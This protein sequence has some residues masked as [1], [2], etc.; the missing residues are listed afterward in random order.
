[1]VFENEFDKNLAAGRDS[2]E[3]I[4]E[5]RLPIHHS[6]ISKEETTNIEDIDLVLSHPQAILQCLDIIDKYKWE[7]RDVSSTSAAVTDILDNRFNMAAIAHKDAIIPGTHVLR[8][9]VQT[10]SNNLTRFLLLKRITHAS[11]PSNWDRAYF[12]LGTIEGSNHRRQAIPIALTLFIEYGVKMR[13]ITPIASGKHYIYLVEV[14]Y[15]QNFTQLIEKM[16]AQ[17]NLHI[18]DFGRASLYRVNP[19]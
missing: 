14:Y 18:Y 5:Y 17:P 2:I 19:N 7:T 8:Q 12:F 9:N 4:G 11:L 16:T 13:V 6:L 1:M 3:I 10:N 15:H